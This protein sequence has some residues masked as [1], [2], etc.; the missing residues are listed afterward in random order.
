MAGY[1]STAV[2]LGN[3][4][5]ALLRHPEQLRLLR[6]EPGIIGNAVEEL[7]RFAQ[8][9]TGFAVAKSATEDVELGGAVI[10]CGATV[11]LSIG[12]ADR[13]EDVFG[14]D[15]DRL[16]LTRPTAPRQIAFSAGPHHCL[17]AA[18]AR[19]ELQE[20]I[21]R[22]LTRF[23]ELHTDADLDA[24]PLASNLFTHYPR[25]LPLIGRPDER[26]VSV[27]AGRPTAAPEATA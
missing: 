24:I 14:P 21:S 22:L 5:F 12:S 3:A 2:Q 8:I 9:G 11:F 26:G 7:L 20:G 4:F 16:D 1:E 6:A 15:A 27:H 17:G 18:L 25:E 19:A 23:P 13:D 10:P